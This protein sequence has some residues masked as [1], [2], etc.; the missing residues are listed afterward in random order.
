VP[1]DAP[2]YVDLGAYMF[3]QTD[4]FRNS[5]NGLSRKVATTYPAWQRCGTFVVSNKLQIDPKR[6][7]CLPQEERYVLYESSWKKN[8]GRGASSE[9]PV[10]LEI[11]E[12]FSS[13]GFRD[14]LLAFKGLL[15]NNYP[16]A[17]LALGGTVM[18]LGYQRIIQAG[19]SCPVVL[20]TG[21][22]ETSK[23]TV[24]KAC[25]SVTGNAEARDYTAKKALERSK[26]CD[27]PFAW[28][29]PTSKDD[30]KFIVQALFNQAGKDTVHSSGFP[31]SPPIISANFACANDKRIFSRQAILLFERPNPQLPSQTMAERKAV[32]DLAAKNA[33]TAFLEA[34]CLV[35]HFLEENS[36]DERTS[37]SKRIEEMFP[38]RIRSPELYSKVMWFTSE[39]MKAAGMGEDLQIIWSYLETKVAPF[40]AELFSG[41]HDSNSVVQNTDLKTVSVWDILTNLKE[42]LSKKQVLL[43]NC[44]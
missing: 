5:G 7:L 18:S 33:S 23:T 39:V 34:L 17:C 31:R 29:D 3:A 12:P 40:I 38:G 30:V 20:L 15:A 25:I 32:L 27:I 11:K 19:G 1:R 13:N 8:R 9:D 22:T 36:L 14:L 24:L 21:D 2:S 41:V 44:I 28:D 6:R 16:A 4:Q 37:I 26:I 43:F 42:P 35:E 10:H